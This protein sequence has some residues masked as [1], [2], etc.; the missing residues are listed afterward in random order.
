MDPQK[1]DKVF[2]EVIAILA[3]LLLISNVGKDNTKNA[4]QAITFFNELNELDSKDM[5]EIHIVD[6]NK[7]SDIIVVD[8]QA[9]IKK[10][11]DFFKSCSFTS[12]NEIESDKNLGEVLYNINYVK[13]GYYASSTISIY[14]DKI[15]APVSSFKF[16]QQKVNELTNIFN[17]IIRVD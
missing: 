15:Y 5:Q 13:K 17:N 14:K 9:D 8:D 4:S 11:L 10:I 3:I 7:P 1:S 16:K 12:K 6:E 2:L